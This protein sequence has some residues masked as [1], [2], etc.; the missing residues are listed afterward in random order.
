MDTRLLRIGTHDAVPGSVN[1]S[2]SEFQINLD[3][4]LREIQDDVIGFSVDSVGFYNLA[5][6]ILF[7]VSDRISITGDGILKQTLILPPGKYALYPEPGSDSLDF[8][9]ALQAALDVLFAGNVVVS[10]EKGYIT[11]TPDGINETGPVRVDGEGLLD[12]NQLATLMGY[13]SH[14]TNSPAAPT[15]ALTSPNH[16]NLGGERVAFF[17]SDSLIHNKHSFDGEGLPLSY[18]CSLPINVPYGNF[19]LVLLN[20]YLRPCVVWD[21]TYQIRE[22]NLRLRNIRG[23]LMDLQGTEWYI[24]LR[25]FLI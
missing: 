8:L 22:I 16:I 11:L 20:Q 17:H 23:E 3:N 1:V 2:G 18:S 21:N 9:V 6:N 4:A 10:E 25:M 19:N 5:R 13:V 7:E 14:I 24:V 15:L 12:S